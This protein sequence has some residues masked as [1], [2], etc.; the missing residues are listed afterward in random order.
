M[1]SGSGRSNGT[2]T[3]GKAN[4]FGDDGSADAHEEEPV[5]E[6]LPPAPQ[7]IA[8]LSHA[9]LRFVAAKYGTA[10]DGTPDTLSLLDQYVR[11]ARADVAAKPETVDLLQCA[12]GAYLGEV[13]RQTFGGAWKCEGDPST[14]RLCMSCVYLSFNPIGM[15]RE[16]LLGEESE[17]WGAHLSLDDEDKEVVAER[18]RNLGSVD[19][20]EYFL[21]TSRFDVIEVAVEA[22]RLAMRTRGLA[23]VRFAVEDYDE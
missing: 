14:W 17:G 9:C 21:P 7:Q 13:M 6:E 12:V 23:D 2:H 11:D 8:E 22:I 15:A 16:A 1:A 20:N 4:G 10:P 3:N 5:A 19:E 18:L